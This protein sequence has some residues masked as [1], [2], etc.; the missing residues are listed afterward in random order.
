MQLACQGF[1]YISITCLI[2]E[3]VSDRCSDADSRQPPMPSGCPS[4]HAQYGYAADD[5][6]IQRQP[7]TLSFCNIHP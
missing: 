1:I 3:E 2:H 7:T 5:Q 4:V 6:E